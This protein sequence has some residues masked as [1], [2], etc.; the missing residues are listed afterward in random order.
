MQNSA[1]YC[2]WTHSGTD[3]E[4]WMEIGGPK[5]GNAA[6]YCSVVSLTNWSLGHV[7][8]PLC[9]LSSSK[10]SSCHSREAHNAYRTRKTFS[11][12]NKDSHPSPQRLP[13]TLST[14]R[15]LCRCTA[16]GAPRPTDMRR[17]VL[18]RGLR[19]AAPPPKAGC[20]CTAPTLAE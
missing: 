20:G 7:F 1:G 6:T 17:G 18:R 8:L 19:D 16:R 14:G 10:G 13:G 3:T 2:I 12:E 4:L 11:S 5:V 9:S 15:S